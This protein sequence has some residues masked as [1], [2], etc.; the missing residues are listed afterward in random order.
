[1]LYMAMFVSLWATAAA[2][3]LIYPRDVYT[4][5]VSAMFFIGG[6]SGCALSIHSV[7]VPMMNRYGWISEAADDVIGPV[8]LGLMAAQLHFLS[9]TGLMGSMAFSRAVEGRAFRVAGVLLLAPPLLLFLFGQWMAAGTIHLDILRIYAGIYIGASFLFYISGCVRETDLRMKYNQIRTAAL[10]I[11]VMLWIYLSYYLTVDRVQL[12]AGGLAIIGRGWW[13]YN[14]AAVFLLLAAMIVIGVRYGILGIRLIF[15]RRLY[16]SS[17]RALT[18]GTSILN[19]SLKNEIQKIT[20]LNERIRSQLLADEY[21]LAVRSVDQLFPITGHMLQMADQIKEKADTITLRETEV[22]IVGLLDAA[23]AALKPMA[24]AKNVRVVK[25][26]ECNMVL[27]CDPLHLSEVFSNLCL[28]ALEAMEDGTGRL[29]IRLYMD[30]RTPVIE[31]EDNGSGIPP[32]LAERIF[33]PF[34]T[35]KKGPG[36]YGLGLS[37]CYSVMQACGGSVKIVRTAPGQGTTFALAFPKRKW[38]GRANSAER[39]ALPL[40]GTAR[41]NRNDNA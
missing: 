1:M 37:Y 18:E 2:L 23:L 6:C 12:D 26:Y 41:G 9:Y 11:P 25:Q 29:Y 34:F 31:V 32:E 19:H 27:R 8:S 5:W 7:V 40:T 33:D 17:M 16:V 10:Y 24:D 3:L 21:D 15:E 20:Y 4:R 14:Y 28:N 36:H 39:R 22:R 13:Q 35:S 30:K 38:L